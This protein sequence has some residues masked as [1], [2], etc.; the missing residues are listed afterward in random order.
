[1]LI[2]FLLVLLPS[3][4]VG[5]V[6]RK[7]CTGI[8]GWAAN[9]SQLNTSV[10]VDTYGTGVF[11]SVVATGSRPDVGAYLKDNGLHGFRIPLPPVSGLVKVIVASGN[12]T[13]SGGN[14][15]LDCPVVVPP[16]P[17][18]PSP[19]GPYLGTGILIV[20]G[21]IVADGTVLAMWG[22]IK[23]VPCRPKTVA[24]DSNDDFWICT[25][26]NIWKQV[27]WKTK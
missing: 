24:L 18:P 17:P 22:S 11:T 8:E 13:L 25:N 7:D 21:E 23:Q 19:Q 5:Y 4:I 6:E 3:Q 14:V 15:V 1:M 27:A 2:H 16:P 12:V 20:N 9:K 26:A 10:T